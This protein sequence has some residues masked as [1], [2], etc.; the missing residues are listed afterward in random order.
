[1]SD[2]AETV[3]SNFLQSLGPTI[4]D[5]R[6]AFEEWMTDDCVFSNTGFPT[7]EGKEAC[8]GILEGFK[9]NPTTAAMESMRIDMVNIA[10]KGNTV[11]TERI[12]YVI[13][14]DGN[15]VL[16]CPIMGAFE[17]RDG[18]IASWRDHFDSRPWY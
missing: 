17:V 14:A 18:K 1:M 16:T 4:D 7:A 10:S 6:K 3:V 8:L 15:S 11:L 13:D 9:Q 5:M 2:A 12:D